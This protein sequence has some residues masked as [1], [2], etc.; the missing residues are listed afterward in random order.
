MRS[1]CC[2]QLWP[3]C[4]QAIVSPP[5]PSPSPSLPLPLPL[6]T[7]ACTRT[8]PRALTGKTTRRLHPFSAVT[9]HGHLRTDPAGN[10][11]FQ[12]VG[13]VRRPAL[14]HT[15]GTLVCVN[16]LGSSMGVRRW[17]GRTACAVHAYSIVGNDLC[18]GGGATLTAHIATQAVRAGVVG[19]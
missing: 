13:Q 1:C 11:Q 7:C 4:N 19:L 3:S 9:D 2:S 5:P 16:T 6:P 10:G 18:I 14:Y 12:S 17:R 8:T 15:K